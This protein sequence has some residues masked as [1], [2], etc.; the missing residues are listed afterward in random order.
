MEKLLNDKNTYILV[1]KNSALSIER[2]VNSL[3]KNWLQKDYFFKKTYFSLHSS[4]SILSKAYGLSKIHKLNVSFRIIISSVNSALYS[5]AAFIHNIIAGSITNNASYI[6]NSFELFRSLSGLKVSESDILISLDAVSLFTNIPLDLAIQS[7]E[8]RKNCIERTTT[9]PFIELVTAIEFILTS[10]YFTFN[11][12]IYRQ[13]YG[14]P[15]GSSLSPIIVDLVLQDLEKKAL[16]SIGLQLPIYYRYVDDIILAAPEN[17]APHILDTFNSF[18]DRLKFTIEMEDSRC[19]SFLDMLL[20]VSNDNVITVDWFRKKTF[21]RRYLSY[22][23]NHPICHK[24][25]TIYNLVDRAILLSQPM[26]HQKNL[27]ICINAQR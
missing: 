2:R 20:K 25:G 22:F 13:T 5:L 12:I 1:K 6:N 27:K 23:S 11:K 9:I 8:K 7:I 3:L 18:H 4:D 24:I 15:M 26:F 19:L 16:N 10:T 21:S 17:K 14:F